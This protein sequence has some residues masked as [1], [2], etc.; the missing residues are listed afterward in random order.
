MA[1]IGTIVLGIATLAMMASIANAGD[2]LHKGGRT[3]QKAAHGA[4]CSS[5]RHA[6]KGAGCASGH[7]GPVCKHKQTYDGQDPWA[8]CGCNGSYTYPVPPL[9]T[10][11]WR[12]IAAQ[13]LMTDYHS[14]WRFPAIKPFEDEDT[15]G[16]MIKLQPTPPQIRNAKT[17]RARTESTVRRV[18][19]SRVPLR[20]F[21]R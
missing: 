2:P 1:R 3:I 13:R 6:S 20:S 9:Y 16:E 19:T 21:I 18:S 10:Y 14:P 11:H 12:G 8:N 5:C 7:C 17:N 15:A 4:G